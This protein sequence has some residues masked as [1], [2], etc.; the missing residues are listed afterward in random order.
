M[1]WT[2]KNFQLRKYSTE[3][4]QDLGVDRVLLEVYQIH[5]LANL[6]QGGLR[7]QGG[8]VAAHEA[9]RLGSHLLE[10]HVRCELHVL[11]VDAQHLEAA[12]GVR[13]ADVN[14]AVE[15]PEAT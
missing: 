2:R 15:A 12:S 13:N 4:A 9:V 3:R 11:R 7:A 8:H 1:D 14:L 5:L 6:L 10:V